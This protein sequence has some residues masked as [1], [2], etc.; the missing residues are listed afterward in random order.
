MGKRMN[1]RLG[2]ATRN[3]TPQTGDRLKMLGYTL[4]HPTYAD[5]TQ[6]PIVATT[7]RPKLSK[8]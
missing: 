2:R 7:D 5:V 4:L 1:R 3:P 6:A 8:S